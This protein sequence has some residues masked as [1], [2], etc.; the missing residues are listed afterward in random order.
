MQL[1]ETLKYLYGG[2]YTISNLESDKRFAPTLFSSFETWLAKYCDIEIVPNGE[3]KRISL[4]CENEK[5]Y[6]KLETEATYIQAIVDF[7]SGMTDRFAVAL[8]NELLQFGIRN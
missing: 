6:G 7:I 4:D 1:F 8:F 2:K 5:I 3:L